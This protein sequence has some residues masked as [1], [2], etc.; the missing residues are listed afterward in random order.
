[1]PI[2]PLEHART[3]PPEPDPLLQSR[4]VQFR[5]RGAHQSRRVL[6]AAFDL[7]DRLILKLATIAKLR[8]GEIFG[9]RWGDM[10]NDGLHIRRRVYRGKIDTKDAPQRPPRRAEHQP[11]TRSRGLARVEQSH[12]PRGLG[13]PLNNRQDA[14]I[15]FELLAPQHRPTPRATPPRMGELPSPPAQRG[16]TDERA[17][18]GRQAR[19]RSGSATRWT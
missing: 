2:Q 3:R 17:G 7:R 8:P 4:Q 16:I 6:F 1:V 14:A 5:C 12:E 15:G 9:L 19:R 11:R 13:V 18:R 10:T